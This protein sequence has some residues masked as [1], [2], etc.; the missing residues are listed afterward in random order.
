MKHISRCLWNVNIA[1]V[2]NSSRFGA[3]KWWKPRTL[4]R[5]EPAIEKRAF[6]AGD[7]LRQ[8]PSR[9]LPFFSQLF[10]PLFG[11]DKYVIRVSEF[12]F[13]RLTDLAIAAPVFKFGAVQ[14]LQ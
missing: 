8:L 6:S 3:A 4:V 2:P 5:G 1:D 14:Q 12:F 9:F 11:V 7:S 10:S 13:P